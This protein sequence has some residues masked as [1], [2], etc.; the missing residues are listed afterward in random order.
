[1]RRVPA[2]FVGGDYDGAWDNIPGA[3]FHVMESRD[4]K[5]VLTYRRRE[6]VWHHE[7]R[8]VM[9]HLIYEFVERKEGRRL[10]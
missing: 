1:M 8:E 5:A 10:R 4:R 2:R 9:S 7:E 3:T 6:I